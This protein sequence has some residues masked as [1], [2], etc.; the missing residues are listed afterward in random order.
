MC[1]LWMF[2]VEALEQHGQLRRREVDFAVTDGR[3][4]EAAALEAFDEQ[5]QAILVGPQQ[6][7]HIAAPST[8]DK[9]VPT[10]RV[11]VEHSLYARR[12]AVEAIAHVGEAG[13]QPDTGACR[14]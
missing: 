11:V 3:P 13:D 4:D 5:A 1:A 7:N 2:P 8:E 12:Q 9:Q 6:L 10:E 14:E